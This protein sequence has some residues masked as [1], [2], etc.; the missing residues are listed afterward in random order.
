MLGHGVVS[1]AL[2]LLVGVLYDRYHTRLLKYYGGLATVMPVFSSIFL[3]FILANV[4][5]PGLCNF[6]GELLILAGLIQTNVFVTITSS[7]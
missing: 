3:F 6:V 2:F 1:S 5:F 4:G 7:L